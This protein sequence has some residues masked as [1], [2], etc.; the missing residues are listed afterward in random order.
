MENNRDYQSLK[1]QYTHNIIKILLTPDMTMSLNDLERHAS[2]L[3]DAMITL[4]LTGK[5][6]GKN[7]SNTA[8]KE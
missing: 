2:E 5:P 7:R 1:N 8:G 6:N 3:A 4:K